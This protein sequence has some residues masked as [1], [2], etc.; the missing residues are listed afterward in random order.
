MS[1]GLRKSKKSTKIS[2]V[3]KLI[4]KDLISKNDD[5]YKNYKDLKSKNDDAYKKYKFAE[6]VWTIRKRN[7]IKNI[8]DKFQNTLDYG[9]KYKNETYNYIIT[10]DKEYIINLINKNSRKNSKNINLNLNQFFELLKV[11]VDL[12]EQLD[13][14]VFDINLS[15]N[16]IKKLNSMFIYSSN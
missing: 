16:T 5:A 8:L 3:S 4:L 6:E 15:K 1:K 9:R 13:T 7:L 2:K 11:A 14:P 12:E 10:T